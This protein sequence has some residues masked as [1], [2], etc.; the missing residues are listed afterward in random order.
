MVYRMYKKVEG[1]G[2][3]SQWGFKLP[4]EKEHNGTCGWEVAIQNEWPCF[5]T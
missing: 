4:L 1:L 2:S 3:T 5:S